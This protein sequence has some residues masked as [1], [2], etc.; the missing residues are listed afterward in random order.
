MILVGIGSNLEG[1][2]GTP[3]QTIE[4]AL[5][6]LNTFPL[7]LKCVSTLLVT[8]P[9]GVL[10]QPDFVNAVA[11]LETSLSPE[12]LISK[13]HLIERGA[14]RR[15][16]KR[17]GARTLD[18]DL[19][20]YHGLTRRGASLALKPLRLPH[21]GIAKRGF[22]LQPIT[23]VAPNWR[24]PQLFMTAAEMLKKLR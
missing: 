18:L 9:F 20:S 23:E 21:P 22:V 7:R 3:L 14:G 8:K 15:R 1:P 19:L 13:L 12:A 11:V 6:E 24:H 4:R 16:R 2:W 5:L 10:N 17:W